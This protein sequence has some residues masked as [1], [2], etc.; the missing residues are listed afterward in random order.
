MSNHEQLNVVF[1]GEFIQF[2]QANI[3]VA[4][5]GFPYGLGI[6]S[7]LRAQDNAGA[8]KLSGIRPQQAQ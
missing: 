2:F 8:G 6:F 7:G 3:S 1:R 5:T 4:N